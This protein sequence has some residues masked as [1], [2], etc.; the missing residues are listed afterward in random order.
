MG[1]WNCFEESKGLHTSQGKGIK[2]DRHCVSTSRR[3]ST[4]EIKSILKSPDGSLQITGLVMSCTP[5]PQH[6]VKSNVY[7]TH[8]INFPGGTGFMH[9]DIT[10]DDS[11]A[12]G[13][14]KIV[15]L[16]VVKE[17]LNASWPRETTAA[18]IHARYALALQ[19]DVT[20][21]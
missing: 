5:T 20:G 11:A 17:A 8:L 18:Q 21:V 19:S 7:P 16:L 4:R 12:Q 10:C 15:C 1:V 9:T 2:I 6:K 13:E 3:S 14:T